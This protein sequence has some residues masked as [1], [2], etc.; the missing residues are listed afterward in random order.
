MAA[1]IDHDGQQAEASCRRDIA[2]A[3]SNPMGH[4]RLA[5]ILDHRDELAAAEQAL[6]RAI[7][8]DRNFSMAHVQLGALLRRRGDMGGARQSFYNALRSLAHLADEHAIPASELDAAE[9]RELLAGQLRSV[10]AK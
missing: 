3:P 10:P 7:Y 4:Y 8:L 9:L 2:A 6:R 5:L 1:S